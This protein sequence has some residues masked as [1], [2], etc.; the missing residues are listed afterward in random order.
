MSTKRNVITTGVV[1]FIVSMF[2]I[3]IL[4]FGGFGLIPSNAVSTTTLTVTTGTLSSTTLTSTASSSYT[5]SSTTPIS[6]TSTITSTTTAT[7]TTPIPQGEGILSI[8]LTDPPHVPIGVTGVYVNYSD[9]MV[10]V[11][12]ANGSRGW[13]KVQSQGSINLTSLTNVAQTISTALIENGTYNAVRFNITSALVTFNDMNYTAFVR[14]AMLTVPIVG[15]IEVNSSSTAVTLLDL[16]P[17]VINIGSKST[18]EFI[19]SA[20]ATAYT[21]PPTAYRVPPVGHRINLNN[22]NWWNRLM[23]QIPRQIDIKSASLTQNSLNVVVNNTGYE[24]L[25]LELVIVSQPEAISQGNLMSSLAGTAVFAI[26]KNGT[27]TP[28]K[29]VQGMRKVADDSKI[30]FG[31]SGYN[32]PVSSNVGLSYKG[33][34][35][36]GFGLPSG[37]STV[38]PLQI[39]SGTKYY[40]TVVAEGAIATYLV[41]AG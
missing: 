7:S 29:V 28:L 41:T 17:T 19:I 36:L 10:H 30:V 22:I 31:G 3:S 14:T 15:G 40:V 23:E 1:T 32:L 25:T 2:I 5:T 12:E 20:V 26:Q 39:T 33:G 8:Q 27:L 24:N 6:T 11:A 34:I 9:I 4:T 21:V 13:L 37:K 16:Q 38:T 35:T 18:P